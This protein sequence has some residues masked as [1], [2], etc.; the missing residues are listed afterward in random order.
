MHALSV[1]MTESDIGI[2]SESPFIIPIDYHHVL[3][4]NECHPGT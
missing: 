3:Q 2:H 4:K 1:R